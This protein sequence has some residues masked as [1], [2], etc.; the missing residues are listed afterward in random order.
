LYILIKINILIIFFFSFRSFFFLLFCF[1]IIHIN[2]YI[3]IYILIFFFFFFFFFFFIYILI[4]FYKD[5]NKTTALGTSKINYIDPRISAAWCYKYNVPIEK[6]FNKSLRNKF[7]WAV[8][9]DENFV[10]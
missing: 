9:V 2:I 8:E 7:K 3:Y 10:F 6:I 4:I 5:E 1:N